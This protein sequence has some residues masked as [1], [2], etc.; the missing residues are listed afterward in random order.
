MTKFNSGYVLL[1]ILASLTL[2]AHSGTGENG[3]TTVRA[4]RI[5]ASP[6]ISPVKQAG[7]GED[8]NGPSLIRVPDWVQNRLGRYYL[9]FADHNGKYIRLAYADNI[10]GPWNIHAP[11]AL[12]IEETVCDQHIASPDAHVDE[13]RQEIRL[14]F[15]CPYG[16]Q[17]G[18]QVSFLATSPDGLHFKANADVLG[19]SYFRVFQWRGD[20]YALARL[21]VLYRSHDGRTDFEPAPNPFQS[22]SEASRV[23]HLAV[24][25]DGSVLSVFYSRIGDAPEGILLST[26][27]LDKADWKQWRASPPVTILKPEKEFEGA[28]EPV[29]PSK[30]G[31]IYGPVRQLRDPAVYREGGKDFLLYSVAGESG[32]GLAELVKE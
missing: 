4:V 8:V 24:K 18:R 3:N 13:G 9:Y 16:L 26:I 15:H 27:Q 10:K 31:A 5:A 22:G 7:I 23:R 14:Y 20:Y 30:E 1:L 12:R 19:D 29:A 2:S 21:G 11:G 17:K 6:I 28:N 32:I 25:L